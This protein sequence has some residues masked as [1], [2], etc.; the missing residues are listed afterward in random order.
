MHSF[1]AR[2]MQNAIITNDEKCQI[3]FVILYYFTE[4]SGIFL[5]EAGGMCHL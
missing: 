5:P 1:S 4:L 3:Y 2:A